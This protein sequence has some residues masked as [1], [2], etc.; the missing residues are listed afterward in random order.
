M[1]AK[2]FATLAILTSASAALT[3]G[4]F[5]TAPVQAAT[6]TNINV[7][8]FTGGDIGEGLDLDGNFSY[9]VNLLGPAVGSIRDANFT[10]D[11]EPGVTVRAENGV[12]LWHNASYGSTTNDDRLE[13]VMQ[14]IRWSRSPGTVEVDLANL[15]LGRTYKGQLLFAES[16]YDRGFDIFAEGVK[17]V[18]DFNPGI[19]QGGW[20]ITSKAA[21]VSFEFTATDSMLNLALGGLAPYSDK[22]P[23]LNGLTLELLPEQEQ[24]SV[25]EPTSGLGLLA[26]GAIGAARALKRKSD[27]PT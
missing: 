13:T 17:L 1:R 24:Q 9:A 26:L 11:N 20:Y 22:N 19:T 12:S 5:E 21:V 18:D 8:S 4:T 7:G 23:I 14:S 25:P 10:A 15:I 16:G 3:L 27:Q 6:F 2:S